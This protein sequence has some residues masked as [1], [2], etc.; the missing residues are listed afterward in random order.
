[1]KKN[2][3]VTKSE[4]KEIICEYIF[5]ISMTIFITAVLLFGAYFYTREVWVNACFSSSLMKTYSD[6]YKLWKE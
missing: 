2:K 5:N 3:C 6:C 1:M 4:V